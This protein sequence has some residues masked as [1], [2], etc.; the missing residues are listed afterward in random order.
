MGGPIAGCL[1]KKF[2]VA[3]WNRTASKALAHAE[4]YNTQALTGPSPFQEGLSEVD[5]ILT[6]LP[7]S[8]EVQNFARELI[9]TPFPRR[10]GLI[11]IDNTSGEPAASKQIAEELAS[12]QIAFLDTPVSGGRKG[13]NAAALTV[14]LS[15][16]KRAADKSMPL[17][18]AMGKN[19]TY[20]GSE[21]GTAHA[22][23]GLNNLLFA[24]N[25]LMAMKVAQ[26]LL[27]QGLDADAAL[28]AMMTSSGGSNAMVRVHE[29]V[30]HNKTIDYRFLSGLLVK[31]MNIGLSQV[32]ERFPGD[33]SYQ[34]FTTIRDL[35]AGSTQ[36][37]GES[38]AD[39]FDVYDFIERSS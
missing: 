36:E 13:A 1:S 37:H 38:V 8:S 23:K 19:I 34:M 10:D 17:L 2:Q 24:S 39:V 29:Y 35:Y 3:V 15:G 26:S 4:Q 27:R 33:P 11:W 9:T 22:I 30:T 28:K 7:T 25:L 6:C 12:H 18:Q 16:D 20:L 14:T 5:F 21:V 31:D 32:H